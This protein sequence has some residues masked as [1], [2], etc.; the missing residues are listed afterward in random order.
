MV[1]SGGGGGVSYNDFIANSEKRFATIKQ[2]EIIGKHV[3]F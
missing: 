1:I 3:T 2:I